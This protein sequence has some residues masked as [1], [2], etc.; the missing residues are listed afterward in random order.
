MF[1]ITLVLGVIAQVNLF[2]P[3]RLEQP[4]FLHIPVPPR[5]C[6]SIVLDNIKD[7]ANGITLSGKMNGGAFMSV[8][9]GYFDGVSRQPQQFGGVTGVIEGSLLKPVLDI[10]PLGLRRPCG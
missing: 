6:N 3:I 4:D 1:P 10:I 7:M 5:A 9:G 2:P 8:I